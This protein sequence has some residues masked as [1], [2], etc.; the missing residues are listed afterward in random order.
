MLAATEKDL[1]KITQQV[2]RRTRTLLTESVMALKVGRVLNRCR[3]AK[4][5]RLTNAGDQWRSHRREENNLRA[6]EVISGVSPLLML[7][8]APIRF[9]PGASAAY[10][11]NEAD[12]GRW[13]WPF[14]FAAWVEVPASQ[15]RAAS[16]QG[17][18]YLARRWLAGPQL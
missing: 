14:R 13:R 3:I 9:Q 6:E 5:F 4:Q 17:A 2:T 8:R 18:A 15:R 1:E 11:P 7:C 10:P 12:L 16:S